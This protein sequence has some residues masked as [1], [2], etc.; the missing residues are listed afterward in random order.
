MIA[1]CFSQKSIKFLLFSHHLYY[2]S[3]PTITFFS[4]HNIGLKQVSSALSTVSTGFSTPIKSKS[5][6]FP[7][8]FSIPSKNILK[9]LLPTFFLSSLH[10]FTHERSCI[11]SCKEEEKREKLKNFSRFPCWQTRSG[12]PFPGHLPGTHSN[13]DILS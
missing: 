12:T 3:K 6:V 4:L 9:Q 2:F 11:L 1:S 13:P 10:N 5:F 8:F 7:C